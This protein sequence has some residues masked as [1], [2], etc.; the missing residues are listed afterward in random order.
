MADIFEIKKG[1]WY[2]C[3]ESLEY[4]NCIYKKGGLYQSSADGYL[5]DENGVSNSFCWS[6]K[7]YFRPATPDEILIGR[8]QT[9]DHQQES[10][11]KY[12]TDEQWKIMSDIG[13]PYAPGNARANDPATIPEMIY[14][15]LA[16]GF[17][18]KKDAVRAFATTGYTVGENPQRVREILTDLDNRFC[19][20]DENMNS[21]LVTINNKL[22]NFRKSYGQD[23][24]YVQADIKWKDDCTIEED[25][26][27]KLSSEIDNDTDD[28]ILF[29]CE[30]VDSFIDLAVN[31][32]EDFVINNFKNLKLSSD[33]NFTRAI[34]VRHDLPESDIRAAEY[35]AKQAVYDRIVTPSARRFTTEQIDILEH[36]RSMF[37]KD[38][39]TK[40]LF[41]RLYEIVIKDADVSCKPEKW[42]TD[43]IK[44]LKDLA[45]GITRDEAR[46]LHK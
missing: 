7:H 27:I 36:Y 10:V 31:N 23:P 35:A 6:G 44:E 38:T 8:A 18:T 11:L 17:I 9:T 43:T 32:K 1:N 42:Q 46:G 34:S 29:N 12:L 41:T 37:T 33:L 39:D 3:T 14:W 45:E 13:N 5:N 4:R 22:E 19:K 30:N 25:A 2:V 20:L 21:K 16:A 28:L 24:L 26:I 40:E 15:R